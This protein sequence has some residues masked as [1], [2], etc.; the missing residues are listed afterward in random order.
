MSQVFN[1]F[2]LKFTDRLVSVC[3]YNFIETVFDIINKPPGNFEKTLQ[4]FAF[5][6][7]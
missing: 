5:K 3:P 2:L 4:S 7:Y 6:L 1:R